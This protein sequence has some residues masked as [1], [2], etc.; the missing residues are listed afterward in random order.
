MSE[1]FKIGE[2]VKQG[3]PMSPALFARYM[4]PLIQQLIDTGLLVKIKEIETGILLYA[5]DIIIC[6]ASI[7]DLQSCIRILEQFCTEHDITINGSKSQLIKFN[8]NYNTVNSIEIKNV[9]SMKKV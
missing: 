2:G 8:N 9:T 6:S 1:K 5:D 3:G 4:N 7:E